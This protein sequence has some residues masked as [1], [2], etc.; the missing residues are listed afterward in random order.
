M[1]QATTSAVFNAPLKKVFQAITDYNKYPEFMSDVKR[2]S[3]VESTAEK[4]LVEFEL[5]IIKT[6]RYQLW[7][8]E[9]PENEVSWKFHTGDIF[10]D[11]SGY[12]KLKDMGDGKTHVDYMINAKFGILVPGM[13]EKKLIETNLPSMMEAFKKRS[14]SL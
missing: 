11:N 1:G 9:Q 4:K 12:W 14:E 13:I 3:V 5:S 6:F 10:K 7:L 2:V 8:F